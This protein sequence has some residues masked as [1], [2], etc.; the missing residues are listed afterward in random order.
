MSSLSRRLR[1]Y[2]AGA[3]AIGAAVAAVALP[4]THAGATPDQ[5]Q[6]TV[7]HANL[8]DAINGLPDYYAG[9]VH[10]KLSTDW[11]HYGTTDWATNTITISAFTPLNL[12]YS[13]VAH[14]WSHEVQAYDYHPNEVE[15]VQQL[16]RH[17]GGPG[18]TGERGVEFSADCMAIL[19]GATWTHYTA[20]HNKTWRHDA[21]VLLEGKKLK[22]LPARHD[23]SGTPSPQQGGE[24]APDV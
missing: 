18:S 19:Q 11:K 2:T 23:T 13:V 17:F 9:F 20:C 22:W 7:H 6:R 15:L 4:L 21:R 14:E 12:L 3:A 5:P 16:N 1:R 10:W 8:M 24:P